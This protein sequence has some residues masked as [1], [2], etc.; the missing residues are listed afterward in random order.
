MEMLTCKLVTGGQAGRRL[1]SDQARQR[2]LSE[3]AQ[4]IPLVLCTQPHDCLSAGL[5]HKAAV[6]Y[7]PNIDFVEHDSVLSDFCMCSIYLGNFFPHF[8]FLP[9]LASHMNT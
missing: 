4:Q 8:T 7:D 6:K 1:H 9:S 5:T 3:W 2:V